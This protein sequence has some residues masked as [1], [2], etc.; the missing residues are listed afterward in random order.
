MLKRIVQLVTV[1]ICGMA[2]IAGIFLGLVGIAGGFGSHSLLARFMVASIGFG[3]AFLGLVTA[4][5]VSGKDAERMLDN[6]FW[7][8]LINH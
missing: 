3:T 8:L 6:L 7:F 5:Y 1:T 2:I 4:Y